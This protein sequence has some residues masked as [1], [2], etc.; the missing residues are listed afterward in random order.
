[1]KFGNYNVSWFALGKKFC[2]LGLLGDV[3]V[4]HYLVSRSCEAVPLLS[5]F[6]ILRAVRKYV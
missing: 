1:M 2:W 3:R 6:N 4:Q 5:A